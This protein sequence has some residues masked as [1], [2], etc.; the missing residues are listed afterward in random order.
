MV[1]TSGL[2]GIGIPAEK[3]ISIIFECDFI[4]TRLIQ[5]RFC[6]FCFGF[7]LQVGMAWH[8]DCYIYSHEVNK[9]TGDQRNEEHRKNGFYPMGF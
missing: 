7:I 4:N 8:T 1:D 2:F 9:P 3:Y 6:G 5:S